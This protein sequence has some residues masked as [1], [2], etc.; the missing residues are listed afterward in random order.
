MTSLLN[1]FQT[2]RILCTKGTEPTAIGIEV[3]KQ[4]SE[5]R[6]RAFAVKEVILCAGAINTPQIL[7]LSGIGAKGE[8]DKFNIPL[9]KELPAVGQ[10]LSEVSFSVQLQRIMS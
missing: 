10:N 9:V 8:L 4:D 2:T 5:R 6:F 3:A 1:L 7:N